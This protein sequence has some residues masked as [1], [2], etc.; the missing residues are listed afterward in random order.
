MP[1]PALAAKLGVQTL[2]GFRQRFREEILDCVA[3][4]GAIATPIGVEIAA[5]LKLIELI[6]RHEDRPQ[7]EAAFAAPAMA[8]SRRANLLSSIHPAPCAKTM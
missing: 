1:A 5:Y 3:L 6:L 4:V 8:D 2:S 7:E